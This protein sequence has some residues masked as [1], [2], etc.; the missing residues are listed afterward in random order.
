MW[1]AFGAC[2]SPRPLAR[3]LATL[4]AMTGGRSFAAGFSVS[5]SGPKSDRIKLG[6]ASVGR[7]GTFCVGRGLRV[8]TGLNTETTPI[9]SS[10]HGYENAS[11]HCHRLA[12][13]GRRRLV[14]S[15]A[16][17]LSCASVVWGIATCVGSPATH[18]FATQIQPESSRAM[19]AQV[20]LRPARFGSARRP[21]RD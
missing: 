19:V 7:C 10:P 18:Y 12:A 13:V 11:H 3:A 6:R 14:R 5:P 17:V 20:R 21:S 1:G 2:G 15:G 8:A 16:L 4:T 9:K